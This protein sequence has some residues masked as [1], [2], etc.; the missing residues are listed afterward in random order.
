M[1]FTDIK[2]AMN[3]HFELLSKYLPMDLINEE[4]KFIAMHGAFWNDGIF[5]YVPRN[6][7]LKIPLKNVFSVLNKGSIFSHSIII[8]EENSSISV[9]QKV[10]S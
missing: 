1:I 6:T 3:E 2:T 10:F 9:F 8:L 7:S 4:D 5:I